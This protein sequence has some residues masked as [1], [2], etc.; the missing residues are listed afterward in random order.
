[1]HNSRKYLREIFQLFG[2]GQIW[3]KSFDLLPPDEVKLGGLNYSSGC[4]FRRIF[5]I[6]LKQAKKTVIIR[7]ED[8]TL[9]VCDCSEAFLTHF[10]KYRGS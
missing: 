3:G 8:L 1:M 4:H 2:I 5:K 6:S 10:K 9:S 7:L